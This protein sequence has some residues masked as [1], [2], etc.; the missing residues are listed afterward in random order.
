QLEGTIL[1]RR[2]ASSSSSSAAP[3][4]S[5]RIV[6]PATPV[7]LALRDSFTLEWDT[8]NIARNNTLLFDVSIATNSPSYNSWRRIGGAGYVI[9]PQQEAEI[10]LIYNQ[11]ECNALHPPATSICP[12][13]AQYYPVI[14]MLNDGEQRAFFSVITG[15][16][17]GYEDRNLEDGDSFKLKVHAIR[18]TPWPQQEITTAVSAVITLNYDDPG[19]IY[20][21]CWEKFAPPDNIE[22]KHVIN[23][24]GKVL[25][26]VTEG[27]ERKV[28]ATDNGSEW[29]YQRTD[30]PDVVGYPVSADDTLYF[31]EKVSY[32]GPWRMWT[33]E[34][35]RRTWTERSI[36]PV[37]VMRGDSNTMYD[38]IGFNDKPHF[39]M[40]DNGNIYIKN[41][42][43]IDRNDHM[44][45]S[46]VGYIASPNT[47]GKSLGSLSAVVHNNKLYI[48]TRQL[49]LTTLENEDGPTYVSTNGSSFTIATDLPDYLRPPATEGVTQVSSN[50]W[51]AD[52]STLLHKTVSSSCEYSSEATDVEL[53][54]PE[55]TIAELCSFYINSYNFEC[56]GAAVK[57]D[58]LYCFDD[59]THKDAF[60]RNI[61]PLYALEEGETPDT[62]GIRPIFQPRNGYTFLLNND[63]VF[64]VGTSLVGSSFRDSIAELN[65][66][67]VLPFGTLKESGDVTD[68]H[69][70]GDLLYAADRNGNIYRSD[71]KT[72]S[73]YLDIVAT[74]GDYP[75]I[76]SDDSSL[77]VVSNT[78][79]STLEDSTLTEELPFS[80]I[81]DIKSAIVHEGVLY[82]SA[83]K[84]SLSQVYAY[85]I[86]AKT[87]EST[88]LTESFGSAAVNTGDVLLYTWRDMVLADNVLSKRVYENGQWKVLVRDD[89]GNYAFH[90][91][92]GHNYR[93][94]ASVHTE[95]TTSSFIPPPIAS[96]LS[97]V[98]TSQQTLPI[99][100]LLS[101]VMIGGY[102]YSHKRQ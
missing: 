88:L 64:I 37:D 38:A 22:I 79:I 48:M 57:G 83:K 66:K 97:T 30:W 94:C 45:V 39:V 70:F 65:N 4:A 60:F 84:S 34:E 13:G 19:P 31:V 35:S 3:S 80:D 49:D 44:A 52:D 2:C 85:D 10:T 99:V 78:G 55:T 75:R 7:T 20:T 50:L 93:I 72:V 36:A 40:I 18:A 76:T 89:N 69:R 1:R 41:I 51:T 98:R 5:V 62:S 43:G 28:Y 26:F 54:E 71:T 101:L 46:Q 74:T 56:N 63:D 95:S 24:K 59:G 77:F 100:T 29:V 6:T 15:N 68:V 32:R 23:H 8:T 9:N 16:A 92:P 47:V 12:E 58:I 102:L 25:I 27:A 14:S 11:E 33:L 96:L 42:L 82:I 73:G 81:G 53:L 91:I 86:A 67:E 90:V 21:A 17:P 87:L 61:Y